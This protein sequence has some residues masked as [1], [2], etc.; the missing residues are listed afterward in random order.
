LSNG[1]DNYCKPDLRYTLVRLAKPI[2][3]MPQD[4]EVSKKII[5]II[6]SFSTRVLPDR[7]AFALTFLEYLL[8]MKL[9][10]NTS[11]TQYSDAVKDL[12]RMC[13]LEMQKLAMKFPNDFMVCVGN[14]SYWS[15][16]NSSRTCTI[17]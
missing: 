9:A 11:F 13:S 14:P 1:V 4:P 12:E 8:T 5:Q 7:P 15:R 17:A 3:D 16:T 2:P 6:S 10:D